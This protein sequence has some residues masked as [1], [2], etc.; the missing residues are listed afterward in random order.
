MKKQIIIIHGGETFDTYDNYIAHLESIEL[1]LDR[2]DRKKWKHSLGE[3]LG[4]GFEIIQ[5]TMPC[6]TN[7]KYREWKI[8]LEKFLPHLNDGAVFIGHS[9]GGIF[10][11]KYLSENK[12]KQKIQATIMIAAPF[13][14]TD[15]EYSL[16]DFVL[17]QNLSLL[18]EQGGRCI[19]YHSSDDPVVPRIDFEKYRTKL[20]HADFR[21]A[22][23]K[24]HFLQE[25][26]P[27]LV[28]V[29]LSLE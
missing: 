9:L 26:F 16:A 24:G 8:W 20:P 18:E 4:E 7:A 22:E 12:I 5:P 17:P 14:D 11:A 13:D 29:L 2:A 25:E 10:L 27:E 21:L 15:R 3:K 23:D 28:E 1:D 19:F 6:G